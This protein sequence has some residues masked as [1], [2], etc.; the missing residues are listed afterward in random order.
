[1]SLSEGWLVRWKHWNNIPSSDIDGVRVELLWI[2][3]PQYV[4][5][6]TDMYEVMNRI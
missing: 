1:M 5:S 4:D 3:N 2:E 6:V